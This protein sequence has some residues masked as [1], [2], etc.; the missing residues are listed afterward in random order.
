MLERALLPLLISAK[1][2][3]R[4]LQRKTSSNNTTICF[5][6]GWEY[7]ELRKTNLSPRNQPVT[8]KEKKFNHNHNANIRG[9][10]RAGTVEITNTLS[11]RNT[12]MLLE[13]SFIRRKT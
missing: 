3:Q 13:Q 8:E 11:Y 4:N 7:I 10:C 1:Q 2:T 6:P 5:F 9:A 12:S